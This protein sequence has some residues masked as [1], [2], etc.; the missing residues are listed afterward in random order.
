MDVKKRQQIEKT[1]ARRVVTDLLAAGYELG[2]NDGENVD[3]HH[4]TDQKKIL[5]A[6]F[7]TDEDWLLVYEPKEKCDP[8]RYNPKNTTSNYWVRFVYG[9]DGWDVICDYTTTLEPV[10]GEGT[11]TQK[12]IDKYSEMV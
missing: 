12:L 5:A 11:A 4:S 7:L 1:I 3:V 8:G 6:M 2:V 9:N 10:I